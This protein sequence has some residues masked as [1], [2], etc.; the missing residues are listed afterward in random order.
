MRTSDAASV[1]GTDHS[2]LLSNTKKTIMSHTHTH[3]HICSFSHL[4]STS[5]TRHAVNSWVIIKQI[6]WHT[7]LYALMIG[8]FHR[9]TIPRPAIYLSSRRRDEIR[10]IKLLRLRVFYPVHFLCLRTAY[11]PS[12]LVIIRMSTRGLFISLFAE[13]SD[14]SYLPALCCVPRSRKHLS[15]LLLR[16]DAYYPPPRVYLSIRTAPMR[17]KLY[18]ASR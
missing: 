7:A 9:I 5:V 8:N 1:P 18:Y 10:E 2:R 3:T 6:C 14:V 11:S 12:H 16:P 4:I 15:V 13:F 17:L